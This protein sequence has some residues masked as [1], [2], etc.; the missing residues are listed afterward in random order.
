MTKM[1]DYSKAVIYTIRTGDSLY[2]G[3]TCNFR[4]RKYNH[5]NGVNDANSKIYN[6][7]VYKKIRENDGEWDIK[8]HKE[9]PCENKTQMS[10][11]E[12][13]VRVELNADL[14]MRTC[15]GLDLEKEKKTQEKY[16][17]NN[18]QKIKNYYVK[19]SNQAK[20]RAKQFYNKNRETIIQKNKEKI[21]CDCGCKISNGNRLR[22]LKT[23]KHIKL[24]ELKGEGN[25]KF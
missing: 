15:H 22:H 14:N 11:E 13:R 7:K 5:K 20:V 1:P 25:Q 18:E 12:E 8:I 9:F 3:S 4:N 16:K 10:I 24:M 19:N 17:Q 23:A 2:V 6:F 21:I